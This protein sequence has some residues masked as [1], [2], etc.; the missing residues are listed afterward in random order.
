MER[1]S[2]EERYFIQSNKKLWFKIFYTTE[3]TKNLKMRN[4]LYLGEN[5]AISRMLRIFDFSIRLDVADIFN[6]SFL[7]LSIK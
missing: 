3:R 1:F 7:L 6:Q 5:S 4:I 2:L